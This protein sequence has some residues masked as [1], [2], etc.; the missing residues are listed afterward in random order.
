MM[1]GKQESVQ[2]YLPPETKKALKKLAAKL[3]TS[4]NSLLR[5]GANFILQKHGAQPLI[6]AVESSE[7]KR[8]AR[9]APAKGV[10]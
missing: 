5:E 4:A 10:R 8:R 1:F 6:S 3:G 2:A 7:T 9:R